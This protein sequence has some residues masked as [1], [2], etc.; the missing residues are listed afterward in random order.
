[1]RTLQRVGAGLLA[2]TLAGS[3]AAC[4][5]DDDSET[6]DATE[7]ADP[8]DTTDTTG[9]D[10]ATGASEDFC[11][12]VVEFNGKVVQVELDETSTEDDITAAGAELAP[13]A[14]DIAEHAPADLSAAATAIDEA[15]QPLTSGDAGPFN[16]DEVF[17]TY[18]ELLAGAVEACGFESVAVSGI[19]Y[20]FEGVPATIGAGT[21]AFAFT[22]ESEAEPHEMLLLRKADGVELSFPEIFE[23]PEEEAMTVTEFVGATFA[24][25][26]EE[27]LTL[28]ELTPGQ[29][30]MVCFVPVGGAEDGPPHFTQGMLQEFTV[31]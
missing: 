18:T 14:A 24:M 31:E 26:G 16:S 11:G 6:S 20:G 13:L 3:I 28:G 23:K 5:D 21:V 22:N 4:G 2:L 15:V 25:P 27:G 12:P 29:Y 7:T 10:D 9:G 17:A 19:D 1:M 8:A 30:A